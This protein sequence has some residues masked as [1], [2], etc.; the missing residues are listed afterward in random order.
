MSPPLF[1][2][3][4]TPASAAI[5]RVL[6]NPP[7]RP[8][9]IAQ[10]GQSLDGRIATST[11]ASRWINRQAALSHLHALRACVD[12]VVVG[13]GTVI[14][15]DPQLNVRHFRLP[16]GHRQPVRVILDPNARIPGSAKCLELAPDPRTAD[17][18]TIHITKPGAALDQPGLKHIELEPIDGQIS[19]AAIVSALA[20]I[21]LNRLLIE[22]GARTISRFLDA[23]VV[24]RLHVLVAPLLIGAG[25]NSLETRAI[26]RLSEARRPATQIHVFEDGD[27]LFDCDLRSRL[28]EPEIKS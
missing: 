7:R 18:R 27:V 6:G 1:S 20:K 14:A 15:D 19:P 21:G 28:N 12:A 13:V 9:I 22:G 3:D 17:N 24:D 8:I 26:D 10:L 4:N 16:D 23:D 11:G 25:Q 2:P 5:K